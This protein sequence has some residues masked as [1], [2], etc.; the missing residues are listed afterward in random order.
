M[1]EKDNLSSSIVHKI[2]EARTYWL[3]YTLPPAHRYSMFPSFL[4][5]KAC[6]DI[7][8]PPDTICQEVQDICKTI[9]ALAKS[10]RRIAEL[11]DMVNNIL[12]EHGI[13]CFHAFMR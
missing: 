3:L 7:K 5:G 10:T 2:D 1:K 12:F 13:L 9:F 11:L 8:A 6:D 4:L